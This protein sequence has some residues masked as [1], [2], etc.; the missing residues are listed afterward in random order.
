MSRPPIHTHPLIESALIRIVAFDAD[1]RQ[2]R[3]GR[4]RLNELSE[5]R[6]RVGNKCAQQD[7]NADQR[8]HETEEQVDCF[9]HFERGATTLG[10]SIVCNF[11]GRVL[12]RFV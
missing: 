10:V 11:F 7:A 8:F 6:T 3:T 9:E 5:S 12:T 4:S 1:L 2:P